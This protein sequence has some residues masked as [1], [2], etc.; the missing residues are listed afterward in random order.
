MSTQVNRSREEGAVL[1]PFTGLEVFE[2]LLL[3]S[4]LIASTLYGEIGIAANESRLINGLS[5]ERVGYRLHLEKS[6]LE[7]AAICEEFGVNSGQIDLVV[8]VSDTG[9]STLH[10]SEVLKVINGS[11]LDSVVSLVDRDE[12]RCRLMTNRYTGFEFEIFLV[13]NTDL[14][15]RPLKPRTRGTILAKAGFNVNIVDKKSGLRPYPLTKTVREENNL[16]NAV[17][18]WVEQQSDSLLEAASLKDAFRIYVDEEILNLMGR[19]SGSARS[20][21]L[22]TVIMPAITQIVCA[23][24]VEL[25]LPENEGFL[26]DGNSS[27]VL[28]LLF[29]KLKKTNNSLEKREFVALLRDKPSHAVAYALAQTT[30]STGTKSDI[31]KWINDL[32]GEND[33]PAT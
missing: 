26:F 10:E 20:F 5:L 28:R 8:I 18:I 3:G 2:G 32:I 33:V 17:W 29:Q 30:G 4:T 19:L 27:A 24:S 15:P 25:N 11:K 23:T 16:P 14:P 7:I 13:L 22:Q 6:K 9:V 21:A 1:R 12:Q 31:R